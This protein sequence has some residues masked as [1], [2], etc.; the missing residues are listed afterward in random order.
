MT[1]FQ[2]IKTFIDILGNLTFSVFGV[3]A[4]ADWG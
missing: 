1:Q 3:Q 4:G 2:L